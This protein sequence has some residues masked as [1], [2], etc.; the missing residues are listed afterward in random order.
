MPIRILLV[1]DD[2]AFRTVLR[3]LLEKER[4]FNVVG[5]AGDGLEAL[6]QIRVLS[7]DIILM[8]LAMPRLNGLEATRTIKTERPGSTVVILTQHQEPAYQRAAAQ[9]GADAFLPKT[10]RLA[11]LLTTIRQLTAGGPDE[12][13]G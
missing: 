8:D 11:D 7:P 6:E 1:D 12:P 4:G 13:I 10:T 2:Q 3:R 9:S 5:E